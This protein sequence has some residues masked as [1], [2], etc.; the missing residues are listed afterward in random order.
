MTANYIEYIGYSA[1]VA[2]LI[3]FLMKKMKTLRAVNIIG[4]GLFVTYG[5][6]LNSMPI[7]I[8]N[9]TICVIH[10]FY[11]VKLSREKN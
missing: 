4:C 5:V 3:S 10:I 8:T 2:V 7:I 9:A 11:L 1:S 6:F